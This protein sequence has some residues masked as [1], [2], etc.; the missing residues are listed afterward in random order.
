MNTREAVVVSGARTPTGNFGGS[1]S[2]FTAAELASFVTSAAIERSGVKPDAVEEVI[3]GAHVQAGLKS[4]FARQAAIAA[5]IPEEV[6]AWVPNINCGS[7][8]RAVVS[9]AQDI[10]LGQYDAVIAGGAE[11]MSRAPYLLTKHRFGERMGHGEIYDSLLY[12]SLIDPFMNY[13]MGV[14]AENV[15]AKCGITREMQDE[16]AFASH[17]KAAA[18]RDAGKFDA[19]IVPIEIKSKKGVTIF[20]KDESIRDDISLEKLAAL[21]PVFKKDGGTVTAGNASPVNDAA[22]ALFLTSAEKAKALGLKP[23]LVFRAYTTV[24]VNPSIMGYGP[25]PAINK[26]LEKTGLKKEDI[27]L[28]EINEAFSAQAAACAKDL[29][30]D[31]AKLNVN[32]GAVALGHAVGCSGARLVIV[33]MNELERRNGRYGIASLCIGGGQGIAALFERA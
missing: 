5:G 2:G 4:N 8:L 13:H 31:P 30:L 24:G 1:L 14:T 23:R 9:A 25:V 18:A 6:P 3:F 11:T 10:M 33:L 29:A 16:F 19:E 32:G 17:K 22:A 12:D 26:L 21:K 7:G 27:D 15:A 28:F 20:D